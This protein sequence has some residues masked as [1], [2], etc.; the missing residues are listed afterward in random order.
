MSV[1]KRG[2]SWTPD[3]R[4][5]IVLAGLRRDCSVRDVCCEYGISEALFYQW[6]DRL[7]EGGKEAL[8]RP[9]EKRADEHLCGLH[10]ALWLLVSPKC[11]P[12]TAAGWSL[13]SSPVNWLRR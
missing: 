5:E 9:N 3:E 10:P 13:L 11:T 7:V 12:R 6:R 1:E 4:A 8:R 2:R